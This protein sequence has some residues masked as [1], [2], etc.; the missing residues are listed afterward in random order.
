MAFPNVPAVRQALHRT[1]CWRSFIPPAPAALCPTPMKSSSVNRDRNRGVVVFI[2]SQGGG[3]FIECALSPSNLCPFRDWN[4][5]P[6]TLYLLTKRGV[7][8][9]RVQSQSLVAMYLPTAATG[10]IKGPHRLGRRSLPFCHTDSRH[11]GGD[12]NC[13][14]LTEPYR[15]QLRTRGCRRPAAEY[16]ASVCP[17][18]HVREPEPLVLNPVRPATAKPMTSKAAAISNVNAINLRNSSR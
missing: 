5:F 4:L 17:L 10:R 9:L 14:P 7:R 1:I 18:S 3:A 11:T 16:Q 12:H 15:P 13:R 2:G 6:Q 8:R